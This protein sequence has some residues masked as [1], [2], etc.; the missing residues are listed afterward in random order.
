MTPLEL[1][2]KIVDGSGRFDL[3]VDI[4]SYADAGILSFIN[5]A[6]IHLDKRYPLYTFNRSRAQTQTTISASNEVA[7]SGLKYLDTISYI[8]NNSHVYL[9]KMTHDEFLLSQASIGS[10]ALPTKYYWDGLTIY[11]DNL[12][13][14]GTLYLVGRFTSA[15]SLVDGDDAETSP[16]S[17]GAWVAVY[18]EIVYLAARML[19]EED[20][21]NSTGVNDWNVLIERELMNIDKDIAEQED[22]QTKAIRSMD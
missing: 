20:R 8:A 9:T 18:G 19:L 12:A 22:P 10:S 4:T 15:Y 7:A 5:L 14:D 1:K 3:V 13:I 21:R 17:I 16:N 6:Q 2:K 11:L